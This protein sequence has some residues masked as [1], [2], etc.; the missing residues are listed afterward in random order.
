M[1]YLALSAAALLLPLLYG[2]ALYGQT[3]FQGRPAVELSND[4]LKVVLLETGGSIAS[5]VLKADPAQTNPLW[6]PENRNGA[7][8]GHFLCLDGFGQPSAEEKQAGFPGH[9]EA[10]RSE[11]R[12]AGG[13]GKT[14][15]TLEATLPM[16]QERVTR[17]YELKPGE[18]VLRVRT[19]VESLLGFDRPIA[20]AEHATIG[21]PFLS[22]GVTAVDLSGSQSRTRP[23]P[24]PGR[25]SLASN[26]DFTWPSAPLARGGMRDIRTAPQG[27]ASLDHTTTRMDPRREYAFVTAVNPEKRLLVGWVWRTADFPW[28]QN[29]ENYPAEGV[30]ARGLEFST[31]PYD[32]PRKDAVAL[33]GMFGAPT[34]RWLPAKATIE[35]TFLLFSAQVPEG[36][37]QIRDVEVGPSGLVL[38]SNQGQRVTVPA[39]QPF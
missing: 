8:Y 15:L 33:N 37:R 12:R 27:T 9:G 23:Y 13:D 31:Q 26:V 38:V 39:A 3:N 4:R 21:S 5:L 25:R 19:K 14:S 34:F 32:I 22:R 6:M 10:V 30:M 28:M 16:V 29:W 11:F 17:Q 1:R 7:G 24:E 36:F 2:P 18:S 20:W 35:T